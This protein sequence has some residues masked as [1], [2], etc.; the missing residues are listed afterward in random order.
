MLDRVSQNLPGRSEYGF[1][2]CVIQDPGATLTLQETNLLGDS[3]R[4]CMKEICHRGDSSGSVDG[5]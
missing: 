1:D 5:Q 3:Q 4:R 2:G